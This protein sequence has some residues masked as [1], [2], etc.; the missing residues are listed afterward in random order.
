MTYHLIFI[1]CGTLLLEY[2]SYVFRNEESQLQES[3]GHL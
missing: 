1:N 2:P 3:A